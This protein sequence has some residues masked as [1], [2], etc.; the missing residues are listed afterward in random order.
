MICTEYSTLAVR[1]MV[2]NFERISQLLREAGQDDRSFE[3]TGLALEFTKRLSVKSNASDDEIYLTKKD[4]GKELA[5]IVFINFVLSKSQGCWEK[6]SANYISE[7]YPI[8]TIALWG[9]QNIRKSIAKHMTKH[10]SK[11]LVAS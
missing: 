8:E 10:H 6:S 9:D 11:N 1:Q 2:R 3:Y 4:D 5:R 7:E